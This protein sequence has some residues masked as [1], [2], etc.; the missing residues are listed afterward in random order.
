MPN[1]YH[2]SQGRFCSRNEML[3]DITKLR[4][5]GKD[6]DARLLENELAVADQERAFQK[7]SK[8]T[9][10][11]VEELTRM[12][13]IISD[14]DLIVATTD[15]TPEDVE[16]I[17]S[18]LDSKEQFV[19][20]ELKDTNDELDALKAEFVEA[21]EGK[22]DTPNDVWR[23]KHGLKSDGQ[24]ALQ[25]VSLAAQEAGVPRSYVSY[26]L[27]SRVAPILGIADGWDKYKNKSVWA[28]GDMKPLSVENMPAIKDAGIRE[29]MGVALQKAV[30]DPE[31]KKYNEN[32]LKVAAVAEIAKKYSSLHNIHI[33]ALERNKEVLEAT[34]QNLASARKA[35]ATI[36]T[37]HAELAKKSIIKGSGLKDTQK[38][39]PAAVKVDSTG[40]PVNV[41]GFN[42]GTLDRIV[43]VKPGWGGSGSLVGESGK[44][45]RSEEH[46]ANYRSYRRKSYVVVADSSE[47]RTVEDVYPEIRAFFSSIDSGD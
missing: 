36:R 24:A 31:V 14:A 18:A 22:F 34:R 23:L 10:N 25:I 45:Y 2:D 27:D 42:D 8:E 3:T 12:S 47:T 19:S 4:R 33:A 5:A 35:T 28:A 39:T 15:Y 30:E 46:F 44:T 29:K 1:P 32:V 20:K 7:A 16:Q 38:V 40:K 11:Q 41:W 26:F 43:A 17:L 6:F 21:V 9:R 13:S 37:W